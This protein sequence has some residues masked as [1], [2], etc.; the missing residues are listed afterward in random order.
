MTMRDLET[1]ALDTLRGKLPAGWS[2]IE[3]SPARPQ[4]FHLRTPAGVTVATVDFTGDYYPPGRNWSALRVVVWP[5]AELMPAH[6]R[7]RGQRRSK[8]DAQLLAD[9]HLRTIPYRGA[10]WPRMMVLDL[11]DAVSRVEA[12]KTDASEPHPGLKPRD[13]TWRER[14]AAEVGRDDIIL[15][16]WSDWHDGEVSW[17]ME[18]TGPWTV[19][20]YRAGPGAP[21]E[22]TLDWNP[23]QSTRGPR[24]VLEGIAP[25]AW[26]A[27][28][29]AEHAYHDRPRPEGDENCP[30]CY[31]WGYTCE[32]GGGPTHVCEGGFECERCAGGI[33]PIK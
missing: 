11:I 21:W 14:W 30:D 31:G 2:I 22:W 3:D 32:H 17:F 25:H 19:C 9:V 28:D 16:W 29:A 8:T 20:I 26:M 27:M 1:K 6:W 13:W 18:R 10:H 12:G 15:D 33:G 24:T 4:A 23:K 7:N 5:S